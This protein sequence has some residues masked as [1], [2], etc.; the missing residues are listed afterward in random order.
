MRSL[1][2]ALTDLAREMT[3]IDTFD[4]GYWTDAWRHLA[5]RCALWSDGKFGRLDPDPEIDFSDYF[6]PIGQDPEQLLAMLE[7][8]TRNEITRPKLV[9]AL[10]KAEVN[11]PS[12]VDLA[13]RILAL[14]SKRARVSETQIALAR[15][16][17]LEQQALF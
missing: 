10:T 6:R 17:A 4:N 14:D 16:L 7:V 2:G 9:G 1:F 12:L 11:L 8:A 15:S 3:A 13:S 5:I